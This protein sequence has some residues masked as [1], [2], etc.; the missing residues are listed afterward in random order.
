MSPC[1]KSLSL[2]CQLRP[3]PAAQRSGAAYRSMRRSALKVKPLFAF[4]HES[5]WP[6]QRCAFLDALLHRAPVQLGMAPQTEARGRQVFRARHGANRELS[7]ACQSKRVGRVGQDA[8]CIATC[9][10]ACTRRCCQALYG[11]VDWLSSGY[12]RCTMSMPIGP[13]AQGSVILHQY[14]R[15]RRDSAW[16]D[17]ILVA[18]FLRPSGGVSERTR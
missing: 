15:I 13:S 11:L 10:S 14:G 9:A 16:L 2:P 17:S 18:T 4:Q 3:L 6:E 8:R 5:A 1:W 12:C 7:V